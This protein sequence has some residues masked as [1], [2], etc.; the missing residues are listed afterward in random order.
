MEIEKDRER[1]L[2]CRCHCR[3]GSMSPDQYSIRQNRARA[4]P[5]LAFCLPVGST[6][7]TNACQTAEN[8]E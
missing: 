5:H 1:D 4:Q 6:G 8:M 3:S 7:F 2:I